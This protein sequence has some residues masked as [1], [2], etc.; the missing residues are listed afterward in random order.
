MTSLVQGRTSVRTRGP[1]GR[2]DAR[3][4]LHNLDSDSASR[5]DFARLQVIQ[6]GLLA[7]AYNLRN[8]LQPEDLRPLYFFK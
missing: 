2:I 4:Q 5:C 3:E 6:R 1:D 8:P 7:L